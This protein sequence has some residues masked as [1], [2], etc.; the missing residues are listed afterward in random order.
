MKTTINKLK[1]FIYESLNSELYAL[2]IYDEYDDSWTREPGEEGPNNDEYRAFDR[3]TAEKDARDN[4]DRGT[5]WRVVKVA[6]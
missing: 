1:K 3:A 4:A 5:V 6:E 2:E